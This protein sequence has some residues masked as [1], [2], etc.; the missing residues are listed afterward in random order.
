MMNDSIRSVLREKKLQKLDI[1]VM[2]KMIKETAGQKMC[3]SARRIKSKKGMLMTEKIVQMWNKYSGELCNDNRG[4][5][6][7]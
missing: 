6:P 3:T 7:I 1:E 4:V 2:H 5:K